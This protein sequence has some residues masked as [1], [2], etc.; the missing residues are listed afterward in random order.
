MPLFYF[1]MFLVIVMKAEWAVWPPPIGLV[2]LVNAHG[3]HAQCERKVAGVARD[4]IGDAAAADAIMLHWV[5]FPTFLFL[6]PV[7]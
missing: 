7:R 4:D 2:C 3:Q 1:S 5:T 6:C